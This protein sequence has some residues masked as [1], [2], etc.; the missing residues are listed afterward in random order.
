MMK[1]HCSSGG[2]IGNIFPRVTLAS[3]IRNVKDNHVTPRPFWSNV[4]KNKETRLTRF[5]VN[6]NNKTIALPPI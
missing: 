1:D 6:N 4:P 3:G 2:T 5:V